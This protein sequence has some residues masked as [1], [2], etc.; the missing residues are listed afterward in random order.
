MSFKEIAHLTNCTINMGLG[1]MRYAVTNL[2]K[3]MVQKQIALEGT[4]S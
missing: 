3:M 2:R 1:R 4:W